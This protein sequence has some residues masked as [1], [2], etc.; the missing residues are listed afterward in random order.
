MKTKFNLTIDTEH[1]LTAEGKMKLLRIIRNTLDRLETYYPNVD[2]TVQKE[3][4]YEELMVAIR[5]DS[6][7]IDTCKFYDEAQGRH[8]CRNGLVKSTKCGGVC[9]DYKDKR[10]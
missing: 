4:T 6:Q 8:K 5:E 9:K 7:T 3:V 2:I 10:K 1:P